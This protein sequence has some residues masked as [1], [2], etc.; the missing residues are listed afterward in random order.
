[1]L[2]GALL[3]VLLTRAWPRSG[4]RRIRRVLRVPGGR[5]PT[6]VAR[7]IR[8][9]A[10]IVVIGPIAIHSRWDGRNTRGFGGHLEDGLSDLMFGWLRVVPTSEIRVRSTTLRLV[11]KGS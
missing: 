11:S 8:R 5:I 9:L 1:M 2:V 4:R 10:A 3:T 6:V 7:L